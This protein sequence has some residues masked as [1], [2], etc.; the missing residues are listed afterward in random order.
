MPGELFL[1]K[2]QAKRLG[3]CPLSLK[4]YIAILR[5]K[6]HLPREAEGNEREEKAEE[7][8]GRGNDPAKKDSTET[9]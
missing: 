8:P 2:G 1:S 6:D 5:E 7:K 3:Q 9:D 4:D